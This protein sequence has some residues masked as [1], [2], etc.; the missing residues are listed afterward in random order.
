MRK[1]FFAV[2]VAFL[3]FSCDTV[4]MSEE[5]KVSPF[6]GTWEAEVYDS[7]YTDPLVARDIFIFSENEFTNTYNVYLWSDV[8]GVR[9]R[10]EKGTYTYNDI[11]IELTITETTQ[12][13]VTL[14][15]WNE[16]RYR[17]LNDS[18]Y[19]QTT[20]FD[21]SNVPYKRKIN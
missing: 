17:F 1:L 18:L 19:I 11:Y 20:K 12:D 3:F 21:W 2:C 14:P 5:I 13:S 16:R 9:T 8:Y 15:V 6:L 7:N 4:P 10:V